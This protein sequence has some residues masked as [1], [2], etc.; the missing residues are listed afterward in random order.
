ME[1][2]K[3]HKTILLVHLEESQFI[4]KFTS[5]LED[6]GYSLY[7]CQNI[8]QAYIILGSKSVDIIVL[9]MDE[10]YF[11]AFQFCYRIKKN[12]NLQKIF[13]IGLSA[14]HSRFDI[15]IDAQTRHD[16]KWLNCDLFV[17]KPINATGLYLLIKKELAILE[18]I[19]STE[20]DSENINNI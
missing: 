18:G 12:I 17:H 19:D 6:K 16:R 9:D 2:K 5:V 14:A 3:H 8:E 13:L 15:Y 10:G 11:E 4:S 1:M 20:L 7:H